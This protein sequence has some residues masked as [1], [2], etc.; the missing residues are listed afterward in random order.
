M[1]KPDIRISNI[2]KPDTKQFKSIKFK[3]SIVE[4][5]FLISSLQKTAGLKASKLSFLNAS[6]LNKL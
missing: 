6:A 3:L 5:K 2:K 4:R 1:A